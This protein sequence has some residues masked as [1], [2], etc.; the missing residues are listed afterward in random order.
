LPFVT[1]SVLA[2]VP[3]FVPLCGPGDAE[4]SNLLSLGVAGLGGI[5]SLTLAV[6]GV[7]NKAELKIEKDRLGGRPFS[8]VQQSTVLGLTL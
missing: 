5:L 1:E 8:P 7:I 2:I 3:D 6:S 4:L